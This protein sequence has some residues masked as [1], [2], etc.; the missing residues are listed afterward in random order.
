M[1]PVYLDTNIFIKAFEGQDEQSH[2]LVGLFSGETP[3]GS[4]PFVTS[5][6]TLA[7]LLGVP[8]RKHDDINRLRYETLIQTT[9][10]LTV[11]PVDREVLAAAALLRSAHSLKLPDAI[12]ISTAI[13]LG[14]QYFMSEDQGIRGP[15]ALS[16]AST[17][18]NW[19]STSV[20]VLRP[21]LSEIAAIED[22]WLHP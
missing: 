6:L 10:W 19:Q 9:D 8:Y 14:C 3:S 16:Y 21:T 13:K 2:A 17:T 18:Q 1:Q 4:A 12:H 5:E 22:G 20:Q 11:A 7:E 15:Y